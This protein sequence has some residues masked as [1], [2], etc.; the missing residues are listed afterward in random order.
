[1]ARD[2]NGAASSVPRRDEPTSVDDRFRSLMEGLRTTLPGA[3]VLVAFLL[4]LPV[5]AEFGRLST[6]ELVVYYAAFASSLLASVLLIA[7]SV[8]QR[9]RSP[10]SGVSRETEAHLDV[11]VRLT[12]IGTVLLMIAL[13]CVAYL[14]TSLVANDIVAIAAS[15]VLTATSAYTWFYQ[16]WIGF[17]DKSNR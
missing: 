15:A 4:V 2:S 17:K 5:Q 12:I 16:P 11:A 6:V 3:Q 13:S 14:V 9:I 1:M 7:P 10:V 8:H